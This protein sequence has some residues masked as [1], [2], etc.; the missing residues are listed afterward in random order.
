MRIL[1]KPDPGAV[2]EVTQPVEFPFPGRDADGAWREALEDARVADLWQLPEFRYFCRPFADEADAG[3]N[4]VAQPGLVFEFESRILA[5]QNFFGRPLS[6]GDQA[7]DPSNFA[8]KIRSVGVWFSDYES[9]DVLADLAEAP[10]VYLVPVG[11]DVMTIPTSDPMEVRHWNV[12][13]QRIPV[14]IAA[15]TADLDDG[16]WIPLLDGLNGRF[17]DPR[18]FSSFRAYHNGSD[19]VVDDELVFDS[20]LVG[21]SIWNTRWMLIVPGQTLNA[22]SELGLERF[23]DQV[24]DIKLIFQTYGYSGG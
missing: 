16:G 1:P 13:D 22:D 7:Y 17:G 6:G 19:A 10:R 23:I 2:G 18:R 9:E 15:T 3:G 5:G 4:R 24:S 14:P 21:R 20:R 12:V 11:T 8:T